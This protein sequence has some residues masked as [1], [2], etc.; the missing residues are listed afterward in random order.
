V[1]DVRHAEAGPGRALLLALTVALALGVRDTAA[2]P[3]A[4]AARLDLTR[5]AAGLRRPVDLTPA[6]GD[7][8]LFIVE[9]TGRVRILERGAL[10]PRPFIDVS[11]RLSHGNEQGLLGIAFHPGYARN[12][13]VYINYTDRDG[14]THVVGF[15]VA[16]DR[17]A[18]DPASEMSILTVPQPYSNHNGGQLIFGP[19]GKLY[20][21][22]GDGG[23]AG[24]PHGNAQNLGALLGKIL[25]LDVDGA[26]PYRI[27]PDNP[28]VGRRGARPEIWAYGLRN[29]W[30]VAFDP[31]GRDLYIGDVGQDM[32]EE[33]D[34]APARQG[35]INYGWNALE[36]THR[37]YRGA[38]PSP[39]AWKPIEEYS[40]ADGCCVI[41]GRVYRGS[42]PRLRG[43][44]F[45]ADECSGWIAS[46]RARDGAA[47]ERTRW[48]LPRR[49]TP[50]AFGEDAAGEL[51]VLDLGGRVY[52]ISG[53]TP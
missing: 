7:P 2:P 35:G 40:H 12:G 16:A 43:L 15:H 53:A 4:G 34:V 51:Y 25:R 50:S 30:R 13:L 18:V 39:S 32:W 38:A 3:I 8:R 52:R 17:N 42:I 36:G 23:S 26:A 37:Y 29:P 21:P 49:L 45:Y 48:S 10:R 5:V 33:V 19:D 46:F 44:Y 1:S 11:D 22:L 31:T 28:F 27:P 47:T 14:D 41:G 24:D 6:P 20:V 9:Q